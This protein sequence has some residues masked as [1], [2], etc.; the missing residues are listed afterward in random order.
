MIRNVIIVVAV[1]ITLGT[2]LY[3]ILPFITPDTKPK[4]WQDGSRNYVPQ[5]LQNTMDG[6]GQRF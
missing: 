1:L 5:R 2:G 4:N 6:M 3:F